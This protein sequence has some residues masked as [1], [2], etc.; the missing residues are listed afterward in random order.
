MNAP[1][2]THDDEARDFLRVFWLYAFPLLL[3]VAGF[4]FGKHR[5]EGFAYGVL[6][7][8]WLLY[9]GVGLGLVASARG[10]RFV[11]SLHFLMSTLFSLFATAF[12]LMAIRN[13]WP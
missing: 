11:A 1:D 5:W 4:V 8:S 7:M 13:V 3:F 9:V 6:F 12:A 2:E 10:H